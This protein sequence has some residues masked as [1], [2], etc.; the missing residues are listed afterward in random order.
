MQDQRTQVQIWGFLTKSTKCETK[1]KTNTSGPS[2]QAPIQTSQGKQNKSK[3]NPN[4]FQDKSKSNTSSKGTTANTKTKHKFKEHSASILLMTSLYQW[5]RRTIQVPT[6]ANKFIG[7]VLVIW[8]QSRSQSPLV[9]MLQC[10]ER[11]QMKTSNF[12]RSS[13]AKVT[14]TSI[15]SD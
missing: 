15:W 9:S 6:S 11:L 2:D 3:S 12:N 8:D 10:L 13:E 7:R 1:S 5:P 14:P 4:Q